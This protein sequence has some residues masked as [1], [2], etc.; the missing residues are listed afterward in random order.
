M[1][2]FTTTTVPVIPTLSMKFRPS[3][4]FTNRVRKIVNKT[5][6][7]TNSTGGGVTTAEVTVLADAAISSALSV[8]PLNTGDITTAIT[9]AITSSL[10]VDPLNP[11]DITTAITA[12]INT[13]FP[14]YIAL[15]NG[16]TD[17]TNNSSLI[18]FSTVSGSNVSTTDNIHFNV[19]T[20]VYAFSIHV[21]GSPA[22]GSTISFQLFNDNTN[23]TLL[24]TTI[25]TVITPA[26][27]PSTLALVDSIS[28]GIATL[29]EINVYR[30]Q[31]ST[32]GGT[33]I[34]IGLSANN[35]PS[36]TFKLKLLQAP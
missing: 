22:T 32:G 2:T 13:A 26:S 4:L 17:I 14:E 33:P 23:N 11:G 24:S 28:M 3:S 8:D 36:I 21:I 29:A 20:G 19:N 9:T 16:S 6:Q 25:N 12:S 34:S 31:N 30:I 18:T 27:P 7:Q 35:A 5:L 1:T 15:F 10:S